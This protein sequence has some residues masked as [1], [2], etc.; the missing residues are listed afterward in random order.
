MRFHVIDSDSIVQVG[1][2]IRIDVSQSFGSVPFT[3]VEIEP[4]ASS[5]YTTVFNSNNS[6]LWYLD[7]MY[8]TAGNKVVTLKLTDAGG[9]STQ[10]KTIVAVSVA[11]D[12]LF[13]NDDELKIH[14]PDLMKWLPAG[15]TTWNFIHRKA[16]DIIL[17]EIYK[18][19]ISDSTGT[20]ITKDLIKDI[21][22]VQDW[23]TF[24]ALRIIFAGISNSVDDVFSIKSEK[25]KSDAA[26]ARSLAFNRLAIDYNKDGSVTAIENNVGFR[27]ANLVK[28]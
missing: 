12:Y 1:E 3:N 24:E 25:Y 14:E 23:A 16:Q 5:G 10:T 2:K 28:R 4:E 19:G 11:D 26:S 18:N 9:N 20:K 22:E 6:S 13:S 21:K 27:T 7:W 8:S 17:T 15:K